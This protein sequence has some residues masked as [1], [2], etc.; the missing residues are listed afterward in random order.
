MHLYKFVKSNSGKYMM[1]IILGIGLAT[2]F[3]SVCKG[4]ECHVYKA[5]PLDEI[6]EKT[7]KFDGKCYKFE[8][9]NKKC[10]NNKRVVSFA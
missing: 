3:R 8:S 7:Y 4:K 5:P 1:S 10:D 6:N 9:E 2:I